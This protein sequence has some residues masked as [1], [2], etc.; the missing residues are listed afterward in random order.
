VST[1]A[2]PVPPP[3]PHGSPSVGYGAPAYGSPAGAPTGVPGPA[4]TRRNVPG[5][6]SV[7]LL[8]ACLLL[9]L[10]QTVVQQSMIAAPDVSFEA[11]GLV[12]FVFTF[13]GGLLAI[14][15][16]VLGAIGLAGRDRPRALAGIGLGG[17]I[18]TVVSI[19][20]AVIV[21]NLFFLF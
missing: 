6:V 15:A 20:I 8:G 14:A 11:V 9:Q 18:V 5:L 10:I 21:P 13:V 17:G 1:P 19:L 3:A 2:S 4:A 16:I 12:S 7:I